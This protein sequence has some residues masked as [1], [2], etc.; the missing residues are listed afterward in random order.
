[1]LLASCRLIRLQQLVGQRALARHAADEAAAGRLGVRQVV[2]LDAWPNILRLPGD[3]AH[4]D[5]AVVHAVVA[6]LA[7]DQ[8]RLAGLPTDAPV[9][10]RHLQRGVGGLRA[11]GGEEHVVLSPG[12]QPAMRSASSKDSGWPNWKPGE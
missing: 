1:M 6:L 2:G 11:R 5:A 12:V 9:G 10:A 4:R 8:A 3:A 7:A